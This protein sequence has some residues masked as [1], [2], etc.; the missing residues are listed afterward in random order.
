[1][2]GTASLFRTIYLIEVK[3]KLPPPIQS[4]VLLNASEF[5]YYGLASTW[6]QIRSRIRGYSGASISVPTGIKGMRFRFGGYS[7]IR[8]EEMTPL[9]TGTLYVT[10]QR[11]LFKG[12][13]RSTT[14]S[15]KKVIDA[16]VFLDAIRIEKA[17]GKADYFSMTVTEARYIVALIGALKDDLERR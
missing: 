11:L 4:D 2:E 1:L 5:A 12:G 17:A 9:A 15:L 13:S 10:S 7:P 16:H 14:I 3:G 8:T 6:Q